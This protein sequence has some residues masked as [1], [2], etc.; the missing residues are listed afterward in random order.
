MREREKSF[1]PAV[2]VLSALELNDRTWMAFSFC[3][4][5]L[6]WY[7][8]TDAIGAA[9]VALLAMILNWRVESN[10]GVVRD[11]KQCNPTCF[12]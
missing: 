10:V 7:S 5:L 1:F 2:L 8:R 12:S 3:N 11:P 4:C 9:K 6:N